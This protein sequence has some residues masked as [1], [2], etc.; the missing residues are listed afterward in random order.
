[1]RAFLIDGVDNQSIKLIPGFGG[2][3]VRMY[4]IRKFSC[5][6]LKWKWAQSGIRIIFAYFPGK[7]EVEY[8][9]IYYKADQENMDYDFAKEYFANCQ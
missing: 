8:L 9:E 6:A 3:V 4:K 7:Q 1:M 2:E 5:R